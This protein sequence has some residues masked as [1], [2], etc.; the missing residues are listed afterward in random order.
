MSVAAVVLA[1]GVSRRLGKPK[2]NLVVGGMT[3]LERVVRTVQQTELRPVFVVVRPE[4]DV[5]VPGCE[6]VRNP[7]AEEGMASSLR[8]GVAAALATG[9]AGVVVF[10]CD[11]VGLT[12]EHVQHLLERRD[13]VVA[14]AY[15]GRKGVPAYFPAAVFSDL[16]ALRGDVGARDLL[17]E[18]VAVADERLALDVDTEEDLR[19]AREMYPSPVLTD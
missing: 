6:V 11:Q 4:I 1:A 16:M 8:A 18:A 13:K 15:A 19:L 7:A 2:Q 5:A 17:R 3:L 10:T 9:A 12:A 14:S